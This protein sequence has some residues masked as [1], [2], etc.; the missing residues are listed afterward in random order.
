MKRKILPILLIIT[1]AILGITAATPQSDTINTIGSLMEIIKEDYYKDIDDETLIRGAIDGMFKSL[2]PHSTYMDP[3]EFKELNEFTSGEFSGIGVSIE[4]KDDRITVVSPIE[5]TPAHE[6][7][8]NTGDIII[9]VD[10][11]DIKDYALDKA[12]ALIRGETG[13]KVKLGVIKADTQNTIY[14]ELTRTIIEIE[15]VKYETPYGRKAEVE[16]KDKSIG[17]IRLTEFN[18]HTYRDFKKSI[19]K[20]KEENKTG[21]IIDIRNNPGGLLDSVVNVCKLIIPE[22]PIV[23]IDAKGT[24][25]DETYSSELKKPPFKLAILINGGSASASEILAGAVKDSKIGITVGTKTYGKGTVQNIMQLTNGGGVKLTIAEYMTRNKINIDGKGIEPDIKVEPMNPQN[26]LITLNI[27]RDIKNDTIGL[28]VYS[29]QQRLINLGSDIVLD[30]IMGKRTL[31]AVNE[32]LQENN[33]P[34]VS[35]LN[36]DTQQKIIE[37]YNKNIV[38]KI[39]DNQLE[40]AIK[41]LQKIL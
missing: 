3:K 17:Y 26:N 32:L 28:D 6:A 37:L 20:Y 11:T 12:A 18:E 9:S 36:K 39:K 21:L 15:S 25:N 29:I 22:G 40:A 5:G 24:K 33:L 8:L 23:H 4:R 19:D 38:D 16:I 35:Y 41:E 14:I 7:G 10:D 31:K 27:D 1:I 2:D 34:A 13:T 30:G